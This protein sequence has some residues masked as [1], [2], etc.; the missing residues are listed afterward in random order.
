MAMLISGSF[1]NYADGIWDDEAG[2]E[3]LRVGTS[4][5]MVFVG[6]GTEVT[7]SGESVDYWLIRNSWGADFGG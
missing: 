4:H 5:A 7:A 2:S 1:Y 3:C 6:Y